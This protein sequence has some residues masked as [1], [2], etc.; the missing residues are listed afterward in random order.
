MENDSHLAT[1]MLRRKVAKKLA[2]QKAVMTSRG[3][4]YESPYTAF[5]PEYLD[6]SR[7]QSTFK[8]GTVGGDRA[9][10]VRKLDARLQME[11]HR[12]ISGKTV[13][14]WKPWCDAPVQITLTAPADQFNKRKSAHVEMLVPCRKCEK[15][16]KVKRHLWRKRMYSE[17]CAPRTWN[18]RISFSPAHLARIRIRGALLS[19]S[20]PEIALERAAYADI[21]RF[22]KRLRKSTSVRFRYWAVAEFGEQNGRLHYHVLIHEISGPLTKR[23]LEKQWFGFH[24]SQLWARL[25]WNPQ[26][27]RLSNYLLKYLTKTASSRIRCSYRYGKNIIDILAK[28]TAPV[29]GRKGKKRHHHNRIS[30]CSK[31]VLNLAGTSLTPERKSGKVKNNVRS[32][33]QN[34]TALSAGLHATNQHTEFA[35]WIIY[36]LYLEDRLREVIGGRVEPVRQGPQVSTIHERSHSGNET[37]DGKPEI[38]EPLETRPQEFGWEIRPDPPPRD[39][40]RFQFGC[41]GPPRN[42]TRNNW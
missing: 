3:L 40:W 39:R 24:H 26:D 28:T 15:C 30:P 20:N 38:Q 41:V 36:T 9:A 4:S 7:P 34:N 42:S 10:T 35:K 29:L 22:F 6:R 27:P 19:E 17:L 33:L 5:G 11:G 23:Q 8:L 25:V 21:Q 12:K 16:I 13:A 1:L 32:D 2:V 18:I 14:S 31:L 37:V